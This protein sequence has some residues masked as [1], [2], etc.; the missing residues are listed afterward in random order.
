MSLACS[1]PSLP[2]ISRN[3]LREPPISNSSSGSGTLT[4]ALRVLLTTSLPSGSIMKILRPDLADN[5]G[6]FYNLIGRTLKTGK[7]RGASHAQFR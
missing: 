4:G 1:T 7:D 2:K 3:D 6:L 5:R